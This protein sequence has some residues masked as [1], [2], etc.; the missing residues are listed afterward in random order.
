MAEISTISSIYTLLEQFE[1]SAC[2]WP[3]MSYIT[4]RDRPSICGSMRPSTRSVA[5]RVVVAR[6]S[7]P[8]GLGVARRIHNTKT[9]RTSLGVVT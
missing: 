7:I 3:S 8:T 5:D 4:G 2:S 1:L 9:G 6:F